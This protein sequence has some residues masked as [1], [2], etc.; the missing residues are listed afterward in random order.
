[1][2]VIDFCPTEKYA[3]MSESP[4]VNAF[5]SNSLFSIDSRI[6]QSNKI[7]VNK[8]YKTKTRFSCIAVTGFGGIAVGSSSGELRLYKEMGKN[9]KTLIPS[10]GGN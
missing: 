10:L 7:V 2:N 6:D 4:I 9:A 1:M 8:N 3:Q 5:D